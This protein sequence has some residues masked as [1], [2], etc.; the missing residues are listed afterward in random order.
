MGLLAVTV[1]GADRPE[2]I[3][4]VSGV[5]AGADLD[6]REATMT[7]LGGYAVMVLLVSGD[8][9][10]EEVR[11]RVAP[12]PGVVATVVGLGERL[13][14]QD[15]G[16]GY[17]LSVHGPGR[18]GVLAALSAVLADAGGRITA[19]NA[20]RSGRSHALVADVCLPGHVDVAR[21][22]CRL[23]AT[24]AGFGSEIAFRPARLEV[25]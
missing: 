18:P 7:R 3:P 19:F 15:Q 13:G 16:L 9:S 24:G 17:V 10:A 8:A 25:M 5:L 11:R 1:V 6:I 4:E 20:G 2:V 22:M 14:G 23:T 21:L 12:L